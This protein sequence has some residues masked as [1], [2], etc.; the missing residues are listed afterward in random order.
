M[1]VGI[2]EIKN[3]FSFYMGR[4]KQG[5]IVVITKRSVPVARLV[6]VQYKIPPEVAGLLKEGLASWQG[7]KPREQPYRQKFAAPYRSQRWYPRTGD[8]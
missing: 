4:V 8:E 5:E 6:P 1:D 3:N 2:K 7:G